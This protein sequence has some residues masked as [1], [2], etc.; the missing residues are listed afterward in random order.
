MRTLRC[1]STRAMKTSGANWGLDLPI[2][3]PNTDIDPLADR[4]FNIAYELETC[5][6][7]NPQPEEARRHHLDLSASEDW[8]QRTLPARRRWKARR[9]M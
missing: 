4:Q 6:S 3:I 8:P 1:I 2:H 5:P 9:R 7:C